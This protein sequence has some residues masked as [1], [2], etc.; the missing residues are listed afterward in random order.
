L[1]LFSVTVDTRCIDAKQ[2]DADSELDR[3]LGAKAM[4]MRITISR[5]LLVLC[6]LGFSGASLGPVMAEAPHATLL[7]PYFETMH[8]GGSVGGSQKAAKTPVATS[9]TKQAPIART[10]INDRM[11][12]GGGVRTDMVHSTPTVR[13]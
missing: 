8:S 6:A 3:L 10:N 9:R 5:V 1:N 4:K 13:D 11:G 12:G 7:L 2:P